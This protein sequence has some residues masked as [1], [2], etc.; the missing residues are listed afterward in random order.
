[1]SYQFS[2]PELIGLATQGGINYNPALAVAV[3]SLLRIRDQDDYKIALK[4]ATQI[5]I[6]YEN[7]RVLDRKSYGESSVL[8]GMPLFQPLKLIGSDG[9][10][11]L[12]LESA[13][14]EWDRSKNIV[15]TIVQGRDT[16][17]DEFINNGDWMINV[18]GLLC[19]AEAR[20]P[21][22]QVLHLQQFMDL[23]TSIKIEHEVLNALGIYEI[24][25]TGQKGPKTPA[26]NCQAYSFSAKSTQPLPLI[27]KQNQNDN[28][29]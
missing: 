24:V 7:V 14:A 21:L 4:E 8:P 27:I 16:S 25:V 12:L 10:E 6:G 3:T 11:D 9:I 18:S 19:S 15:S 23:N 28:I 5:A 29:F 2:I 17:V 20:Y 1:M 13:I 22:D 26:I